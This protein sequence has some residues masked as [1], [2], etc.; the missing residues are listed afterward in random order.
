MTDAEPEKRDKDG[1]RWLSG[2]ELHCLEQAAMRKRS[3]T[4][5]WCRNAP[6]TNTEDPRLPGSCAVCLDFYVLVRAGRGDLATRKH[7]VA[8]PRL[9]RH[10]AREDSVRA[11]IARAAWT[12]RSSSEPK[13]H[14]EPVARGQNEERAN[15]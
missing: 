12:R 5:I 11:E 6:T 2:E 10:I 9:L 15:P 3:A 13:A 4:C 8:P 7:P 14:G 1:N